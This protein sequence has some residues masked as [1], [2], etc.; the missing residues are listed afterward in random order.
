MV[1]RA[2]IHLI[3][4]DISTDIFQYFHFFLQILEIFRGNKF[5]ILAAIFNTIWF[6][7]IWFFLEDYI[8]LL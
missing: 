3:L 7:K 8:Q 6:V 4:A 5:Q 1:F 2:V